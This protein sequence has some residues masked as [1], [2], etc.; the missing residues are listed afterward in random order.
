MQSTGTS[1]SFS[2]CT[3]SQAS[4]KMALPIFGSSIASVRVFQVPM[5]FH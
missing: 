3:F 2:T 4:F 5:S 1:S